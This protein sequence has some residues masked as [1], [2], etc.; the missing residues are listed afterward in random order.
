[1]PPCVRRERPSSSSTT[2]TR[3]STCSSAIR[4]SSRTAGFSLAYEISSSRIDSAVSGVRSWW[5]ASDA[6]CRSAARRPAIRSELRASSA[7]TRSISSTPDGSSRG[8]TCPEPSCS[9]EAARYT[10]GAASRFACHIAIA[11]PAANAITAATTTSPTICALSQNTSHQ[12]MVRMTSAPVAEFACADRD[13]P[14]I[15][16]PDCSRVPFGSMTSTDAG[17]EFIPPV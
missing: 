3:R 6:N 13:L 17:N 5:E 16:S 14:S 8:R 10:K 15:G 9:A 1:M 4:A 7:A 11:I 2:D 12:E